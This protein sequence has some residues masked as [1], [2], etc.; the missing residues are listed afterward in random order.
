MHPRQLRFVAG[1]QQIL[2]IGAVF[3]ALVPAANVVSLDVVR[4]HP[5]SGQVSDAGSAS[6][7]TTALAAYETVADQASQVPT[8]AVEATV[9]QIPL[10]APAKGMKPALAATS[11]TA[12]RGAVFRPGAGRLQATTVADKAT[13]TTTIVSEPQDVD[14][15]GTVGVTWQ[16]GE[17]LS[18]DEIALQV[19]TQTDGSWGEWQD[20]AYHDEHGPDAGTAEAENARPGTDEA[21]VG[22]VDQVQV[23]AEVAE[24]KV[25][26]DMTLAVIDPGTPSSTASQTPDIDMNEMPTAPAAAMN[27]ST[28]YSV[29]SSDAATDGAISLMSAEDAPNVDPETVTEAAGTV[30]GALTLT[31]GTVA[32][33]HIYS[34]AQ[35]GANEKIR[36]QSAPDYGTVHGA[37]VHHTVNANNYAA[38]DVPGIL[39]SIYSYHV[40]SRGWRDVGYNFLVDRFGRIWEGRYGGATRAVVGAHTEGYN[41]HSFALSA[42]GNFDIVQPSQ[43]IVGAYAA[44]F[45]W[46]L[47]L[48]GVAASA[49]KAKINGRTF[50]SPIMGHRDTKATACP[51]RYLYARLPD[52]RRATV[53]LQK[54]WTYAARNAN[55]VGTAQ[56]DIIA[57][58]SSDK[59]GV[60]IPTTGVS[61]F[62]GK[63]SS[64][65]GKKSTFVL[66]PDLNGDGRA[67][68][69]AWNRAGALALR[70]GNGKGG[71]AGVS[72]KSKAAKGRNLIV[73]VGDVTGDRKSDLIARHA[74]THRLVVLAG[75]G[76]GGFRKGKVDKRSFKA[77]NWISAGDING[78][79]KV[80][81]VVR[82]TRGTLS[83][84]PGN[85]RGSF[86]KRIG[87]GGG[88]QKATSLAVADFNLDGK[89]DI[90]YRAANK[91]GYVRVGN[92]GSGFFGNIG[93]YA[94]FKSEG[95]ISGA[96]QVLAGASPEVL[97]VTNG[98]LVVLRKSDTTDLGAPV[99]T[100]LNLASANLV[101][102]AGDWNRDGKGDV[103]YRNT[104]GRLYLTLGNGAGTFSGA[105]LL[106]NFAGYTMIAAVG[107]MTGDGFGDLMAQNSTGMRLFPGTGS[108]G[109]AAS[110]T[111]YSRITG[112]AQIPGG[113]WDG[114]KAPDVL[115]RNGSSLV[116]YKGNGP[117]GLT[118]PRVVSTGLAGYDWV[119]GVGP[120]SGSG[121]A[122]L[123]VRDS[124]GTL[125]SLRGKA[126][127]SLSGRRAMGYGYKGYD[128]AG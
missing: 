17:D 50:P 92:G 42:I 83:W 75:N 2:V 30:E 67:D 7:V 98:K 84:L 73:P 21:L 80:D 51:G 86:G 29:T 87:L 103:I 105:H 16:Q 36:D 37:F 112:S 96:T 57:R 44:L 13:G 8:A 126:D 71:F 56:P 70:A 61:G 128:L 123:V 106:G 90:I 5:S 66:S 3:A 63:V 100:N 39:R 48:H 47:S 107:D 31:A 22:H 68:V 65:G 55:L 23:R 91:K 76:K 46:K 82:D 40:K 120:L 24:G 38:A 110:Y 72:A 53:A 127:G 18:D 114:D 58:R 125:F 88:W 32:K 45:S 60:I 111:V 15:F 99:V 108:T 4:D 14:G 69:V 49:T 124:A 41:G 35:W 6:S 52:I 116:L 79:R 74:K 85:G 26:A 115:V 77:F 102:N 28:P 20:L 93:P 1:T 109:V 34:R 122:D 64:N 19:R 94:G 59:R 9:R 12:A 11:G 117:A 10:T 104:D 25:P 118:S 33:P 95:P 78:D 121:H 119:I 101:L 89:A 97:T 113:T 54:G 43:E 62:S 81:L 27:S